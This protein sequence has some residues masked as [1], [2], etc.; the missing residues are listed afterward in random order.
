MGELDFYVNGCST[1][2]QKDGNSFYSDYRF[3]P[4][5]LS[6]SLYD[7]Q[8]ENAVLNHLE[9]KPH[10]TFTVFPGSSVKKLV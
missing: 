10:Y 9:N 8:N 5:N 4:T 6:I 7:L 2:S 3:K 1:Y